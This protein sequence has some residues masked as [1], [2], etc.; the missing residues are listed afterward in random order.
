MRYRMVKNTILNTGI[1]RVRESQARVQ[2]NQPDELVGLEPR[3]QLLVDRQ[4]Q[5]MGDHTPR[6][7]VIFA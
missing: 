3:H 4:Q 2:L 6:L 7:A 1:H 5:V